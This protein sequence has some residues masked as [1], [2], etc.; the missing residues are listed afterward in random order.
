M[1]PEAFTER[2]R[3]VRQ[4][5]Y[6]LLSKHGLHDWSFAFNRRKRHLGLCLFHL[7]TIELSVYLILKNPDEEILD[8]ILHEIAHALVGPG[9]GHDAVWKKKCLEIGARPVRCSD[10]EMP[11]GRWRA[12]CGQCGLD[13]HRHRKPK[14]MS[15]WF[16]RS[17]GPVNGK[18]I[19]KEG[20]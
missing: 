11:L 15:G 5:A 10:A 3:Q 8:T 20:A 18:L 16:C 19:W 2:I 9:H 17:C 14:K 6:D 1:T 13:F 4:L 7:H 12:L